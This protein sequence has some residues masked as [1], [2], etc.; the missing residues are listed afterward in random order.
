MAGSTATPT[1]VNNR[2]VYGVRVHRPRSIDEVRELRER[3]PDSQ[4]LAGGTWIMRAPLRAESLPEDVILLTG[5][6]GL[7]R[8]TITDSVEIG[9]MATLADLVSALPKSPDLRALH[10]AAAKAATPALRN[11]ITV[12]GSIG[13]ESF[14]ASD[15]VPALLCLDAQII[16]DGDLILGVHIARS[17]RVSCHARLTWR[18]GG[19]YS[20]ASVSMSRATERDSADLRI[21]LGSVEARPRRWTEL[22]NAA[23]QEPFTPDHLASLARELV[24]ELDAVSAPGIPAAYRRTVLP[25]VVAQA[26]ARLM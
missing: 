7:D 23:S 15:I 12:G 19:E 21:A 24:E 5:V 10:E 17:D 6:A 3:L 18:T 2:S 1:P 13:A 22:E 20:V 11:M 8:I 4:Y 26:T 14:W 9:A 16:R 25:Q